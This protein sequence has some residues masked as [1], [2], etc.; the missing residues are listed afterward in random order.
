MAKIPHIAERDFDTPSILIR[1][2]KGVS[3]L[4]PDKTPRP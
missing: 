1:E 4:F 2:L 3:L